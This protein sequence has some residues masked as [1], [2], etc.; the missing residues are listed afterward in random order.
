MTFSTH[1]LWRPWAAL[2]LVLA[3]TGCAGTPVP[4]PDYTAFK[5]SRPRSILILPP[6]NVAPDVH[7]P[8]GV[9]AQS[10]RPL[11]ESGY[12]VYPVSLVQETFQQNGVTV[13]ADAQ[14]LPPR[15]LH[16]IFGADAGLYLNITRYGTTY[17]LIDSETVVSIE[18]RLVDLRD[19]KV[20]WTGSASASSNEG[21]NTSNQGLLGLMISAIANQIVSNMTDAS[22]PVA[23]TASA[24]LLSARPPF[25][26]LHGPRSPRYG[27]D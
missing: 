22:F 3:L 10:L 24:R 25:G 1:P 17:K 8:A 2:A 18:A 26:L 9:I 6:T 13:A 11:S 23:G 5:Q 12:Y 20:L 19:G 15:R 27:T 21:R 14:A 4:P 7:A 16:E